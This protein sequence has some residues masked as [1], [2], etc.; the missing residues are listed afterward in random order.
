MNQRQRDTSNR[1]MFHNRSSEK[2]S[3]SY[4]EQDTILYD[5]VKRHAAAYEALTYEK[6]KVWS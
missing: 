1:T 4:L 5:T 3:S 2:L 6:N